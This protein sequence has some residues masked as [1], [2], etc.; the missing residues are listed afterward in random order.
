M[1]K[2][3]SKNLI[4]DETGSITVYYTISLLTAVTVF[5]FVIFTPLYIYDRLSLDCAVEAGVL[6]GATNTY[7]DGDGNEQL[8]KEAADAEA[9][10]YIQENINLNHLDTR[11]N[12]KSFNSE[13]DEDSTGR[14]WYKVRL[15]VQ[16]KLITLGKTIDTT[17]TTQM[18]AEVLTEED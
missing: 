1:L 6:A 2:V 11:I 8:D 13:V 9:M 15:S 18:N 16:A 7:K 17:Y 12:I 14:K 3:L 4:A 10:K 5:F